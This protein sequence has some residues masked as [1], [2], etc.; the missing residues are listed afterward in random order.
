MAENRAIWGDVE[1]DLRI[2]GEHAVDA[3]RRSRDLAAGR[4]EDALS[5]HDRELAVGV[6]LHHCYSA[7]EAA[8]D[9]LLRA[10]D[11]SSPEGFASHARLI[12]EA[13][14]EKPGLRPAILSPGTAMATFSWARPYSYWP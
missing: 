10:V 1:R 4:V 11:G 8:L 6:F 3:E 13:A 14:L 2:A 5:R 7:L 12:E 9:R